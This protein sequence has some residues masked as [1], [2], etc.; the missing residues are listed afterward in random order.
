MAKAASGVGAARD[1][2]ESAIAPVASRYRR[3]EPERTLLHTTVRAHLEDLPRR[4][5]GK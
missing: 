5:G 1:A 4:S 2:G 3:R